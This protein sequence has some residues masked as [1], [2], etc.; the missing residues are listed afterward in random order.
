MALHEHQASGAESGAERGPEF[1]TLN[2][3]HGDLPRA[4]HTL[5]R[6]S[7]KEQPPSDAAALPPL[8]FP[9]FLVQNLDYFARLRI[10]E[11]HPF[12]NNNVFVR[13]QLRILSKDR[14]RECLQRDGVWHPLANA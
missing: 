1:Q 9:R 10:N 7:R 5:R 8:T 4:L 6:E 3:L 2:E 14:L 12:L 13:L 11:H